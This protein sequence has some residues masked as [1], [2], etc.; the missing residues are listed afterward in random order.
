MIENKVDL[1]VIEGKPENIESLWNVHLPY[2]L[3][4]WGEAFT[5]T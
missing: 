1:I 5:P 2:I 3:Q 4:E